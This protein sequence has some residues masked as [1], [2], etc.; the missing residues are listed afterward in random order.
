MTSQQL[1]LPVM[2]NLPQA[3]FVNGD[4]G[5]KQTTSAAW[6]NK[7]ITAEEIAVIVP[8][9]EAVLDDSSYDIWAQIQPSVIEAFG[10]VIDAAAFFGTG[11]PASWPNGIVPD[12][13]SKNHSIALGTNGNLYQDICSEGGL[14]SLVESDGYTVRGFVGPTSIKAKMR[15]A[16][17][18]NKQPIFRGGYANGNTTSITYQLD[19]QPIMIAEN[20]AW[21]ESQA[22]LL[23]GDFSQALYSIRQDITMKKLD[24]ATLTDNAGN[25]TLNLAQQDAVAMRFVMRLG[26]VLPNPINR[27]NTNDTTRYPFAVLKNP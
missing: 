3:Y 21:D 4:T 2:S 16:V 11:K 18:D 9:P 1:S 25:I 10:M 26:W 20:G 27:L 15:G 12:A 5:L 19:G 17:D 22:L 13:I 24:Q 23:G 6:A 7:I 14:E 8:I